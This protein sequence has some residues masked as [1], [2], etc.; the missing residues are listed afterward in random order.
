[1]LNESAKMVLD[2]LMNLT[3]L[4]SLT[5]LS[6]FVESRVP[7]TSRAGLLLQGLLFG[8]AAVIG[9]LKPLVMGPGLI[10]D[11]RSIMVSL[12]AWYFGPLSAF[13]A[14]LMPL[15]LRVYM[16]GSGMIMGVLVVLS[17]AGIGLV[18]RER[19]KPEDRPP[20]TSGLYAFGIA[21]HAV[22]VGLMFT[23]PEGVGLSTFH[24][25]G[26]FVMM[27]YPLATILAGKLLSD[28][29]RS[30]QAVAALRE[31]EARFKLSLE[32]SLA[33]YKRGMELS[34]FC[35]KTLE[36][37]EQQVKILEKGVLKDFDPDLDRG[38]QN[39]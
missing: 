5:I 26:P 17:S 32:A 14:S 35:Q 6:D 4:I 15:L 28:Q 16:G 18:A 20:R 33:A 3:F 19:N 7:R 29:I 34:A 24:R 30:R 21:V 9:M 1:M 10:F 11:G 36:E 37:A 25:V 27:L 8:T 22:M 13:V 38:S 12:C 39:D 23:L 2:L 31:S